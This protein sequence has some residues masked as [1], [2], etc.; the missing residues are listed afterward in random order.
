MR[1]AEADERDWYLW[2]VERVS[3]WRLH[4]GR[5][6]KQEVKACAADEIAALDAVFEGDATPEPMRD[7]G[8]NPEAVRRDLISLLDALVYPTRDR[9]T[10]RVFTEAAIAAA[11]AAQSV[12][13]SPAPQSA[14]LAL[15]DIVRAAE[16]PL[17]RAA[18]ACAPPLAGGV[19][20]RDYQAQSLHWMCAREREGTVADGTSSG[21]ATTD[22][23]V[24]WRAPAFD[25]DDTSGW[26]FNSVTC[27]FALATKQESV[28]VGGGLLTE[29]MGL[30]K[31]VEVV[32]LIVSNPPAPTLAALPLDA[33]LGKSGAP[34]PRG[35]IAPAG[36]AAAGKDAVRAVGT[37]V[38]V[39]LCI[40]Q[41]WYA[42]V[43]RLAPQLRVVG[44]HDDDEALLALDRAA[45]LRFDVV[46]VTY[47][48]LA[49]ATAR[50]RAGKAARNAKRGGVITIGA[51]H[52][53]LRAAVAAVRWHR[54]VLDEAHFIRGDS[55]LALKYCETFR[56]ANVWCVTGTPFNT[57]IADVRNQCRLLRVG[58]FCS[59]SF[60]AAAIGVPWSGAHGSDAR[61]RAARACAALLRA[62]AVR[63][64]KTQQRSDGS[65]LVRLP[66]RA[67]STELVALGGAALARYAK[68]ETLARERHAA[69]VAAQG[70]EARREA[71]KA[72]LSTIADARAVCNGVPPPSHARPGRCYHAR[73]RDAAH[74]FVLP[75]DAAY[76]LAASLGAECGSAFARELDEKLARGDADF[77]CPVCMEDADRPVMLPCGHTACRDC[78]DQC[79]EA[80][81]ERKCS[82]CQKVYDNEA[83]L[84][85]ARVVKV[86][87][88]SGI[89]AAAHAADS[90]AA[91]D[92]G[93]GFAQSEVVRDMEDSDAAAARDSDARSA[94]D[95]LT[96]LHAD[97]SLSTD[98]ALRTLYGVTREQ[99]MAMDD[100]E[101]AAEDEHE[102]APEGDAPAESADDDG[103][104]MGTPTGDHEEADEIEVGRAE[105]QR[106][107]TERKAEPDL[108]VL[109][110]L[111]TPL[112]FAVDRDGVT[113]VTV[114]DDSEAARAGLQVGWRLHRKHSSLQD[115]LRR[116]NHETTHT[117]LT[118]C[119]NIDDDEEEEEQDDDFV[120]A[121]DMDM[122]GVSDDDDDDDADD[123]DSA[124]ARDSNDDH[125]ESGDEKPKSTPM[126]PSNLD[127][128]SAA[129]VDAVDV[130]LARDDGSKAVIFSQF[131]TTLERVGDALAAREL[132]AVRLDVLAPARRAA[133]IHRFVNDPEQ[134]VLLLT[135][136]MGAAGLNLTAANHVFLAEAAPNAATE[137][138]AI[139]RVHR[140]ALVF[141][142]SPPLPHLTC[143]RCSPLLHQNRA[144]TRRRGQAIHDA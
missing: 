126:A 76:K 31:T 61:A 74:R 80:L 43:R 48:M 77:T 124:N 65:P 141:R 68:L 58:A 16:T 100:G 105:W 38:V 86:S 70:V 143:W 133:A 108:K 44:L 111:Q 98:E 106:L 17:D 55:T 78:L 129:L 49:L 6:S 99:L 59:E 45:L 104:E 60:F 135:L 95:E 29:E 21:D 120:P 1:T 2:A 85:L 79:A 40:Q 20:L 144:D 134:C 7:D 130:M 50:R 97:R 91:I 52:R 64:A 12:N 47:E 140:Y 66:D 138:Q 136:K 25:G 11:R 103:A 139:N 5:G 119:P 67:A 90:A 62:V 54:V 51:K 83:A 93:A 27:T 36:R 117:H 15:G 137:E 24:V 69:L 109:F 33:T 96:E 8:Y 112:G 22:D 73:D 92:T 88:T 116:T 63:H 46:I 53:E 75:Q 142:R 110:D 89:G 102:G 4:R 84:E 56:A 28:R 57:S 10:A 35:Y 3:A 82:L 9:A 114:D 127:A 34:P 14:E 118:F 123:D 94:R 87:T 101:K 41:Q 121:E 13:V 19:A 72:L 18:R 113:V 125:V 23:G 107:L 30:G 81:G 71:R 39:P 132:D 37:L 131:A 122:D 26:A 115:V 42:E 128:K 32:A